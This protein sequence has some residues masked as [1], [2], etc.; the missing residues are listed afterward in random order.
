MSEAVNLQ[1]A[2]LGA[3]ES[4]ESRRK[5]QNRLN[6][7]ASRKFPISSNNYNLL[8]FFFLL[9]FRAKS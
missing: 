2:D 3:V 4:A 9:F 5:L 8:P 1:E 7:R 6:Q